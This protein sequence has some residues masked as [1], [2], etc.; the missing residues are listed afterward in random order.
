[1][2]RIKVS[3]IGLRGHA[4]KHIDFLKQNRSVILHRVY[5]HKSPPSGSRSLPITGELADCLDSDLI[6]V[7]SPTA[8]HLDYINALKDFQGYILLEKPAVNKGTHVKKLLALPERFKS[9]IR[10]NFNFLFDEIAIILADLIHSV[11]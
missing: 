4:G 2:D 11:Q 7:S 5:Y 3:V 1:M 9:R 8:T 10:V 6:I